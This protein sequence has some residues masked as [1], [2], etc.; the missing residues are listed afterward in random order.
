MG[1][2]LSTLS[3]SARALSVYQQEF[4]TIEN[5]ITNA[6]T[7][8][9][10]DQNLALVADQFDPTEGTSGGVSSAGLISSQSEYPRSERAHAAIAAGRLA[11]ERDGPGRDPAF[12]RP[13]RNRW[14]GRL[15]DN[16]FNSFS[17]L[18]VSPNDPTR[19]RR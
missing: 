3:T 19:S 1:G 4:S 10:A 9:Y 14:R 12:L 2:I 16:F 17:A 15:P 7:P 5:N 8:G 13:Q 11:A 18:S 6:N